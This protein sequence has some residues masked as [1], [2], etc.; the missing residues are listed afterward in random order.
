[1]MCKVANLSLLFVFLLL[2][3]TCFSKNIALC[4]VATNNQ[5]QFIK[6]LV[7]SARKNFLPGNDLT[8]FIFT[9]QVLPVDGDDIQIIRWPHKPEPYASLAQFK[10]F[11]SLGSALDGNDY[12][13]AC[14]PN[15]E[16]VSVIDNEI[17]GNLVGVARQTYI[18]IKL[19]SQTPFL[20]EDN[21][22]S[23]LWID[24]SLASK[25]HEEFVD[26][27]YGG[28]R[29]EFKRLVSACADTADQ[30]LK[31]EIFSKEQYSKHLNHFFWHNTPEIRLLPTYCGRG[32]GKKHNS[33]N[34]SGSKI[35]CSKKNGNISN[36]LILGDREFV[37]LIPSYNNVKNYKLNLDSVYK[38]NYCKYRVIYIDDNSPDGTGEAVEKYVQEIGKE[39]ITT[40]I[41]NSERQLAMANIYNAIH[42]H[43]RDHEIIAILDGDDEFANTD[44]LDYLNDVYKQGNIWLTYGNLWLKTEQAIC[45]W[46]KKIDGAQIELNRFRERDG[47]VTALRTFGTWLFKRIKKSDLQLHGEFFKM[48]YDVAMFTPMIEMAGYHHRFIEKALYLYNDESP[49]ND[50]KVDRKLQLD[51]NQYIRTQM[52][53]Y[54]QISGLEYFE[55]ILIPNC[56]EAYKNIVE[57]GGLLNDFITTISEIYSESYE[58]E[59]ILN[60]I[61][62]LQP[63]FVDKSNLWQIACQH[64]YL[65]LKEYLSKKK[66]LLCNC[67]KRKYYR[68]KYEL[69]SDPMPSMTRIKLANWLWDIIVN[70][71]HLKPTSFMEDIHRK[72]TEG[73]TPL[74]TAA[75]LGLPDLVE[76]LLNLGVDKN[77]QLI[78]GKKAIDFAIPRKE[79]WFQDIVRLLK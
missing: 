51:L 25:W 10:A 3:E 18:K 70:K 5:A 2:S 77:A 27:F 41:R 79:P 53:K 52:I 60:K 71:Y 57:I 45:S 20:R 58:V 56:D 47:S 36:K 76:D 33:L 13:Y 54:N 68:C 38:Q 42:Q 21:H 37:I 46:S 65:Y 6:K 30:D 73:Y 29:E 34:H 16:F 22:Q 35:I 40:I 12:V 39:S 67:K 26:E 44:V 4:T 61:I 62:F 24:P 32:T 48:A 49:I 15:I 1:M 17:L 66:Y 28:S 31:N 72:N 64:E 8:F 7:E 69:D 43:C 55:K 78:G 11:A 59:T 75:S 50:H 74:I 63:D 14:D 23:A 9:D 19:S